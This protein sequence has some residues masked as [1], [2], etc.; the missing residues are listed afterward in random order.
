MREKINRLAR[1]ILDRNVGR[2]SFMPN[3]FSDRIPAGAKRKY[4]LIIDS[5]DTF[6][7]K[8]LAYSDDP[9]IH[10]ETRAFMGRRCHVVFYVDTSF[11]GEDER[12][13]GSIKL[14]TNAGEHDIAYDFELL[15]AEA[16]INMPEELL[17]GNELSE[18][19]ADDHA[20]DVFDSD[21]RELDTALSDIADSLPEDDELLSELCGLLIGADISL[22]SAFRIY[23][24]AVIRDIE[25][26][27]LYEYYIYSYPEGCD[28]EMP[29]SV[30]IYFSYDN[31]LEPAKKAVLY[32]NILLHQ[33]MDSE[34]YAAYEPQ[35]RDY[36]MDALFERHIDEDLAVIYDHMLF[37]NMIDKRA[38][39]VLPDI[40]K[41]HRISVGDRRAAYIKLHFPELDYEESYT[42]RGGTAYVP[43]YFEDTGLSFLDD[44][45]RECDCG[46][47]EDRA[48]LQ[49]PDLLKRCFEI[50]PDHPM[51]KLAAARNVIKNGV[52]NDTEAEILT[53]AFRKLRLSR[54]FREQIISELCSHDGGSSVFRDIMPDE[55]G[56]DIRKKLF[57]AFI[58]DGFYEEAYLCLRRYGLEMAE[59]GEL[60]RLVLALIMAEDIPVINGE[61]DG[62]FTDACLRAFDGGEDQRELVEFL[63]ANYEGPSEK[64][65][66]I[67]KAA[68]SRGYKV[69]DLPEKV[70]TTKLFSSDSRHLD[71]SFDIYMRSC[72]Q[73]ENIVCA[74]LTVRCDE[75]FEKED[76]SLSSSFFDIL[77]AY[78][79]SAEDPEKLPDIYLLALTRHY[80]EKEE[81]LQDETELCQK[82]VD[83]L[84]ERGLIFRYTKALKKK[85]AIPKEIC[86][87]YYIE[88]HGDRESKPRLYIRISPEDQDFHREEMVRIYGGIYVAS[89]ILFVEDE[90]HYMIYDDRLSEKPVQEGSISVRKLH[91][92]E[93][94]RYAM[95][96]KMTKELKEARLDELFADLREYHLMDGMRKGLF[97]IKE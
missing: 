28:E 56:D 46:S 4:D 32:R 43:L 92:R 84:I 89:T 47:F 79:S 40:L 36:A 33:D 29:K 87:R 83:I 97:D 67:A 65:Y 44:R 35:I 57:S 62:F 90:L 77:Y 51:L 30:L 7:I 8:G 42:L 59:D 60:A 1:G 9:R 37:P 78:V 11:L 38:A 63:A 85:I 41:S 61:L 80:G 50:Y 48:M 21:Q 3:S 88:Y 49:R 22:P 31:S 73:K 13:S 96:D 24:E 86:E 58:R 53:E 14:I 70:I 39:M 2:L 66:E 75:Y 52:T 72:E 18:D 95:L 16:E 45:L 12:L 76:D 10:L 6:R 74:Y 93:R 82:L 17:S 15:S 94:D 25:L 64:M 34:L 69:Y 27:K 71:E 19:E 81:L 26:T 20:S 5:E 55:Y 91:S 23:R 54:S 68:D